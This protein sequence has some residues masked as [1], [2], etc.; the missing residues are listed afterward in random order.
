MACD[1]DRELCSHII[2]RARNLTK[3]PLWHRALELRALACT[4]SLYTAISPA[5]PPADLVF[6]NG[7]VY[8][9]DAARSWATALAVNGD[10]I[11]YVGT[12]ADA[13]AFIGPRTRLIDLKSRML[14]PG[15]QDSHVHPSEAPNPAS[16][17]DLHGLLQREQVFAHIREYARAHPEKSW[18]VGEGWD[19]AAFLPSGQPTREMLDAVVPDRPAFLVNNSSHEAWANSRALA[20]AHV[21]AA[22]PDPLN[23]R[24]ERDARGQ[25]TGALQEQAQEL[26]RRV[27][28]APTPAERVANLSAALREMSRLGITALEDAAVTPEIARAYQTLDRAHTL[29]VRATLCQL[30]R[31]SENDDVQLQLFLARRTALAGHRLRATCVKIFLD[32]A[33]GSHTVVLLQPY[34]DEPQRFGKGKLFVDPERL[35]R[36]VTRLDA[37]GFQVHMHAIGDGAVHAGLDAVAAAR[38]AHGFR[39]NRDTLA[40]L[41]LITDAD[42]T[43]F[44]TLGVVANMTPLWSVDDPWETIFAPRLFGPERFHELYQTRTLLDSGAILVWGSDWPVTG[45]SPLEGLETAITHRYPGG[46]DLQGR[47][48]HAWKPEERVSLEQAIV[49]YTAAGAYLLHDE[50]SRGSLVA[51]KAADLVVLDRNLFETPP[52]EIHAVQ[53]DMTIVAGEVTFERAGRRQARPGRGFRFPFAHRSRFEKPQWSDQT[54]TACIPVGQER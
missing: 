21:T 22:T 53:V 37:A 13:R 19:E 49:A 47:E 43:R 4:L 44:R 10:R 46:K 51:G 52:L 14:L 17:L 36:L 16:S 28:P 30:Y 1:A 50:R 38:K 41:A 24:I 29:P 54:S 7:A 2:T 23:G 8:T 42:V 9:V 32:G 20:A 26:V 39:D 35:N 45:V 27:V 40:H 33:Y 18:I 48:D 15:F 34:S 31:P 6:V 5:A 11:A 25:P 3:W 12:D